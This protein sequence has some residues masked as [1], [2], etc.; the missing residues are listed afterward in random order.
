MIPNELVIDYHY[1]IIQ[2]NI[3]LLM[4]EGLRLVAWCTETND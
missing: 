4:Y 2:T 3:L 1:K